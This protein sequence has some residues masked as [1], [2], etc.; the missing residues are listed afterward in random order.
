MAEVPDIDF[1]EIGVTITDAGPIAISDTTTDAAADVVEE[2]QVEAPEVQ[3]SAPESQDP[4]EREAV[5]QPT[6][7]EEQE[8][9]QE[10]IPPGTEDM[11][12]RERAM[13]LQLQTITAEVN[14]LKAK[15]GAPPV[16]DQEPEVQEFNFMEGLDVDEVLSTAEGLNSLMNA[17][18]RKGIIDASKMSAENVMRR[19]PET[20]MTTTAR[21]RDMNAI[22]EG[23]YERNQDLK[24]YGP[25]L[26]RVT[27]EIANDNPNLT[28]NQVF[29][30]AGARVRTM[31]KLQTPTKEVVKP[32]VAPAKRP[33]FV[34]QR[35][36]RP[37]A[38]GLQ[39]L[40]GEIDE[41][42]NG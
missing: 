35:G 26:V 17:V 6:T 16:Q 39:G 18:Y 30:Q 10:E 14:E 40:V 24:P 23:W 21:Q 33:A 2:P 9:E 36:S 1:A 22:V 27:Q 5:Q 13:L 8:A 25:L 4:R 11:T 29:D 7:V 20:I 31:M 37:Q 15:A 42:I 3:E 34:G 32:K 12:P 28:P 41:L 19:L 38:S